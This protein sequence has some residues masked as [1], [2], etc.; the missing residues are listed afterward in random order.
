M[1]RTQ[2]SPVGAHVLAYSIWRGPVGD[3]WVLHRCDNPPC[4]RPD[5]LFLGT[6]VENA[7]DMNAKGRHPEAGKLNS[8]KVREILRL[9]SEEGLYQRQIAK[10]FGVSQVMVCKILNGQA[11]VH[12]DREEPK[13]SAAVAAAVRG[14]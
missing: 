9:R 7:A 10:R 4:C 13:V 6:A 1:E 3:R 2:P 14:G 5:H 11:W 8:N 12:V